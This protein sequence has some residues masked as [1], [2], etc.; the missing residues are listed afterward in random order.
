[1][2]DAEPERTQTLTM[3]LDRWL[4][5]VGAQFLREKRPRQTLATRKTLS[6]LANFR[7]LCYN[8]KILQYINMPV[9]TCVLQNKI[10]T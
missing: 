6:I 10:Q 7:N 5:S 9:Q 1:L 4:H 3:Q 8:I 2:S